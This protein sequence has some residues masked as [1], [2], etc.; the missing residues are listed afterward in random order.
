MIYWLK[1]YLHG[2]YLK[3]ETYSTDK[4]SYY[5]VTQIANYYIKIKINE[6]W[7]S[8]LP[9]C[10]IIQLESCPIKAIPKYLVI[11]EKIIEIAIYWFEKVSTC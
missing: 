4:L 10:K 11:N 6:H 2:K 8:K 3:L 9:S 7:S 1:K 5:K